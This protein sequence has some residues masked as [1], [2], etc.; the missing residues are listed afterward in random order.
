MEASQAYGNYSFKLEG[1]K[2]AE[3]GL[4][5]Y[6]GQM[7]TSSV[8]VSQVKAWDD[9]GNPA[10]L[11]GGGHQVTCSPITLT[12]YMDDKM[13]LSNWYKEVREKGATEDT[14]QEPTITCLN[15]GQP[16]RMWKLIGCVPTSHAYSPAN[17]QTH[18]LMTETITLTYE[19][20][21]ELQ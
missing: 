13:E 1:L 19:S 11:A 21:E 14:K 2:G 16:L 4:K 15:N 8:E 17:A 18:G 3:A 10:P 12:R 5:F 6:E 7:P 9:Q 20:Y